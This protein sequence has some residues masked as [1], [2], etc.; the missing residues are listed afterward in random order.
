M[1]IDNL[2][3]ASQ[4]LQAVELRKGDFASVLDRTAPGDFVYFDPPYVPL[5][6]TAS[7]T[8]YTHQGFDEVAQRRLARVCADLTARGC[9]VMLSNSSTPLTHELYARAPHMRAAVVQA[10]RKINCD[11]K[12]RGFVDE[13]IVYNYEVAGQ[14]HHD[15]IPAQD[16]A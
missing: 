4:A 1:D 13:L 5:S 3:A 2:R 7:F 6:P 15:T 8:H 16:V 12:K 11:G 14:V 10:S 9:Y